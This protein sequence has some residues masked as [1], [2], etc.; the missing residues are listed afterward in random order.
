MIWLNYSNLCLSNDSVQKYWDSNTDCTNYLLYR[1]ADNSEYLLFNKFK[2]FGYSNLVFEYRKI[3]ITI[4]S[5]ETYEQI[6]DYDNSG[7]SDTS[8][9]VCIDAVIEHEN[10]Y[11]RC[12]DEVRKLTELKAKLKVLIT[13]PPDNESKNAI[14]EKMSKGI[15]QSNN[16]FPE[17]ST[18]EYLLILGSNNNS[19]KWEFV[20]FNSS[21]NI[22]LQ[23]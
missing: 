13:Y 17:N 3:D 10:D 4:F 16:Y 22:N 20:C 6:N 8:I 7:L 1:T 14:I 9:P 18:T 23:K 12:F 2:E 11:Q 19:I 15:K 21:G 5:K